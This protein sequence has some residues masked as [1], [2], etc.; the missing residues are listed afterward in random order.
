MTPPRGD[1]VRVLA[2]AEDPHG[3]VTAC[4]VHAPLMTLKRQGLISDYRVTDAQ[5]NNV[6]AEYPFDVLW[7]QRVRDVRLAAVLSERFS[8]AFMHDVDDLLVSRPSYIERD[9]L[10][11]EQRDAALCGIRHCRVLTVPSARLSRLLEAHAGGA[12][13]DKVHVCPNA[14]EF[15]E[16]PPRVPA[17]PQGFILTQSHRMALTTSREVVLGTMRDFATSNDLPIYYFGPPP[18]LLG[19]GVAD[20]LGPVVQCGYLDFWRYHALLAAWPAMIGLAPLETADDGDTLDFVAGKSDVKMVEFGGFGHPAVYS[21]AA[22]YVD[23]DL[24]AGVLTD[25]TREAW[26]EAL[27]YMLAEGWRDA[28]EQQ[29]RVVAARHMERVARECWFPALERSRLAS[30]MTANL[31]RPVRRRWRRFAGA[32]GRTARQS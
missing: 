30:P 20:L 12:L 24:R 16:Q 28:G 9:E 32:L 22:P 5:L 3:L 1:K 27:E 10:P 11:A 18:E 15:P 6:E 14:L 21:R 17:L 26:T 4:R 13:L 25:N 31:L 7:V 19:I 23:T 29:E 2:I 8:G